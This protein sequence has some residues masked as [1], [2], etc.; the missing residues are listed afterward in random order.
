M[1]RFI[2]AILMIL[3]VMVASAQTVVIIDGNGYQ[4]KLVYGNTKVWVEVDGD[5]FQTYLYDDICPICHHHYGCIHRHCASWYIVPTAA[6]IG[7]TWYFTKPHYRP[8]Y[9]RWHD[10]H[11]T[12]YKHYSRPVHKPAPPAPKPAPRCYKPEPQHY[13]SSSRPAPAPAPKAAPA[14]SKPSS[15]SYHLAPSHSSTRPASSSTMRTSSPAPKSSS[16]ST[17]TSSSSSSRTTVGPSHSSS[18][19]TSSRSTPSTRR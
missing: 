14:Q 6:Y 5:W 10:P 2:L 8:D 1:K 7:A 13:H 19:H 11:Y 16:T 15:S 17:R 3:G 18:S 9:Y 4:N 12:Y